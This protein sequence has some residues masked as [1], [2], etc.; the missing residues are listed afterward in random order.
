MR[1][2]ANARGITLVE[3]LVSAAILSMAGIA[4]AAIL[5]QS[6]AGWSSVASRDTAT[7]QATIALQKLSN[8]IRDGKSAS[9]SSGVLTVVFPVIVQ[10]P[11]TGEEIYDLSTDDP[12]PRHYYVSADNLIRS[13]GT[14]TTVFGRGVGGATFTA[15]GGAVTVTLTSSERVGKCTSTQQVT[16]RI[17]LRN[18]QD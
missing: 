5:V 16:G 7:S 8:D 9:V 12:T 15:S 18:Y 6:I 1:L 3:V 14:S 13:A 2:T 17:C 10:D 11:T 4:L